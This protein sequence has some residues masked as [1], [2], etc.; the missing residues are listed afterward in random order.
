MYAYLISKR[1]DPVFAIFVGT[2][3]AWFK[4]R[5]DEQAKGR[6]VQETVDT[7]KRRVG[8]AGKLVGL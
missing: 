8:M 3:S 4:V 1:L 5:K 7:L 6:S 2:T